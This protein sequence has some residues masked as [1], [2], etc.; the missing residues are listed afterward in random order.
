VFEVI[1]TCETNII[2]HLKACLMKSTVVA[3]VTIVAPQKSML[4]E[5]EEA[6]E[7]ELRLMP[8]RARI[9]FQPLEPFIEELYQS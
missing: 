8:Y 2:G 7:A 9:K 1:S 5:L 3:T 6:V 4:K